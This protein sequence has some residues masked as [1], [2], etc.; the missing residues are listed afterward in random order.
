VLRAE[1]IGI[2]ERANGSQAIIIVNTNNH[3]FIYAPL[4]LEE[5]QVVVGGAGVM[6]DAP[7]SPIIV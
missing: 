5:E 7:A 1:A 2:V 3:C 4:Y 6:K